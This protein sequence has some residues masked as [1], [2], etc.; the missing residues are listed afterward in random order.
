M[1]QHDINF[2]ANSL[3]MGVYIAD[4]FPFTLRNRYFDITGFSLFNPEIP[5]VFLVEAGE[6]LPLPETM[7]AF[8]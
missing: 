2:V 7:L 4:K 5:S 3:F 8:I 1:V 6:A